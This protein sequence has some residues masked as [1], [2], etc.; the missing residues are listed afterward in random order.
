[1]GED[2]NE[3]WY[4]TVVFYY[5]EWRNKQVNTRTFLPSSSRIPLLLSVRFLFIYLFKYTE[6]PPDI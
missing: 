1:M 5:V 6:V 3:K 2:E 4:G